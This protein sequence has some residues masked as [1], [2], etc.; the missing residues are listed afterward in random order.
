VTYLAINRDGSTSELGA[1]TG[2]RVAYKHG[3]RER[4]SK[5]FNFLWQAFGFQK[6]LTMGRES[7]I[8]PVYGKSK[9]L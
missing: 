2:Y 6:R 5:P 9:A 4:Y 3:R 1:I 7:R 8:V